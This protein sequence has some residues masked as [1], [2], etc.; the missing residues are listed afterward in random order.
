MMAADEPKKE[1]VK[2]PEISKDDQIQWLQLENQGKDIQLRVQ[3]EFGQEINDFQASES[4][5]VNRLKA[6]CGEK[7][8]LQQVP[9]VPPQK[10]AMWS[11]VAIQEPPKAPAKLSEPIKH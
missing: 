8:N 1:S 9:Q 2:T 4:Q 7:F 3:K 6:K 11:C 10:G 5:F